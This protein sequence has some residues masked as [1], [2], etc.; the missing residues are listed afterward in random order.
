MDGLYSKLSLPK[1]KVSELEVDMR[2][3]SRM[4][5]RETRP[6]YRNAVKIHEE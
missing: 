6:K 5:Q 3:L 1:V 2:N 4:K